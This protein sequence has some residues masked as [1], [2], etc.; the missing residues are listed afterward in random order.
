MFELSHLIELYGATFGYVALAGIIFAETGLFFG[1]FL[2]GDSIL[3]PAGLL[4][5]QGYLNIYA[6]CAIA[7]VAATIG[8]IVGYFLGKHLGKRLFH[9]ED[10][11]FFHKDHILRARAFY[12]KYGAKTIIIGRFLPIIR[13]FAP[14]VAG[15]SEMHFGK[16][17]VFS[18][19]GA[20]L[21]AVGLPVAGFYL[22]RFIPDVDKLLIPVILLVIFLSILPGILEVF[23]TKER[24]A[25]ILHHA[26]RLIKKRG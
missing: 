14:V 16:Y 8:N 10:S 19:I 1:F 4:A 2:P 25:R 21:W 26:T 18:A 5:S 20:A 22:G 6:I 12:D 13:T 9:R 15:I 17:V 24:R 23:K 3:F 7:F 11:I